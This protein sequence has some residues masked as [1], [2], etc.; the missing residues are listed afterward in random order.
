[1]LTKVI[2][3]GQLISKENLLVPNSSKKTTEKFCLVD[4]AKLGN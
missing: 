4:R 2:G 3:K 1:M